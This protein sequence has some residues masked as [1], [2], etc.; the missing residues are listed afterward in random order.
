MARQ[1]VLFVATGAKYV[2][3]A[4]QAAASVREY[5]PHL[6]IALV[7]DLPVESDD[8]FDQTIPLV[9]PAYHHS[10]KI[11]GMRL[12]PYEYTLF[13]ETDM[14]VCDDIT[15]MFQLL[16]RFD[17]AVT[18][19]GTRV[20]FPCEDIPPSFC[21]WGTRLILYKQSAAMDNFL[22]RWYEIWLGL[23]GRGLPPSDEYAFREAIYHSDLQMVM[24]PSEYSLGGRGIVQGKVKI[25]HGREN[26]RMMRDLLNKY[27]TENRIFMLLSPS[28]SHNFMLFHDKAK[29]GRAVVHIFFRRRAERPL[30]RLHRTVREK[31]ILGVVVEAL[32]WPL[33]MTGR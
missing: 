6:P 16:D 23:E 2:D 4:R 26:A 28:P 18:L 11:R 24:L 8:L 7:T 29:S 14:L 13:I 15:E 21:L 27:P 12:S 9:D 22:A 25:V 33:R 10:D 20:T 1:G 32:R 30:W 5:S 31:G 17:I 3:E 19:H